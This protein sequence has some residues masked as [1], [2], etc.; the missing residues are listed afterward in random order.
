MHRGALKNCAKLS[1]MILNPMMV[2][3]KK[4]KWK[5]LQ[6]FKYL[7]RNPNLSG[8]HRRKKGTERNQR[9]ITFKS[10]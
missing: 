2:K 7:K 8:N 10:T 3:E 1:L 4:K 6:I 5:N 9:I